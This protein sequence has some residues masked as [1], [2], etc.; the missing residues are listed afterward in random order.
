MSNDALWLIDLFRIQ[1]D[2]YR[3][4]LVNTRIKREKFNR[5][6]YSAWAITET[7]LAIENYEGY[8]CVGTIREILKMQLYDY[9]KYSKGRSEIHQNYLYAAEVIE[10][11]LTLTDGYVS[12]EYVTDEYAM[13]MMGGHLYD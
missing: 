5:F 1:I 11:L 7:L 13:N 4:E 2:C 6:S 3:D 8:V 9:K 12:D 10:Y